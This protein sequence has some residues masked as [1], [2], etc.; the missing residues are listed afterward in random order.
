MVLIGYTFHFCYFMTLELPQPQT[1]YAIFNYAEALAWIGI[2]IFIHWRLKPAD[3]SKKRV[4]LV[5]SGVLVVFGLTDVMEASYYGNV[6]WWLLAWKVLCGALLLLG[7]FAYVGWDKF[8]FS[9]RY[10]ITA[11]VCLVAV[12]LVLFLPEIADWAV[13]VLG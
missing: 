10:F 6:P 12:L 13:R 9:D 3:G 11:L 4:L 8:R 2:A 5:V 7:R 1:V